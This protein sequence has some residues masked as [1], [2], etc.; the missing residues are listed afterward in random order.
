M[1]KDRE[2]KSKALK[3]RGRTAKSSP[4]VDDSVLL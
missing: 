2:M 1:G 4:L 3:N